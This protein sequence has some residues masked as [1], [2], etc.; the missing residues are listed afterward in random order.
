MES[1]KCENLLIAFFKN[2]FVHLIRHFSSPII[3]QNP[4]RIKYL[5]IKLTKEVKDLYSE[6]HKILMKE[7]E[8]DR[9]T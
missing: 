4:K 9:G 1:I 2:N 8:D 6:N 3:K 7:I 5:R